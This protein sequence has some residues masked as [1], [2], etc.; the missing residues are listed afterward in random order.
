MSG[1]VAFASVLHHVVPLSGGTIE[2]ASD[3]GLLPVIAAIAIGLPM[4]GVLVFFF[5][6]KIRD[7]DDPSGPVLRPSVKDLDDEES[8]GLDA[9]GSGTDEPGEGSGGAR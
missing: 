5:W 7:R 1:N 4:V 8:D 9:G 6:V 2:D 3:P